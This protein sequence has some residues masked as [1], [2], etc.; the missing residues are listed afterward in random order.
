VP[1]TARWMLPENRKQALSPYASEAESKTLQMLE[2]AL[3][4]E[5]KELNPA[6]VEK[7]KATAPKDVEDLL[8]YLEER[9]NEYARKA[10]EKLA[11]RA[12]AESKAMRE[13][14]ES[15]QQHIKNSIAKYDKDVVQLKIQ[16]LENEFKQMETNRKYWDKRLEYLEQELLTE[17]DRVRQ[18]YEVKARRIEPVGL[19]YLCPAFEE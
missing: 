5:G 17:P 2:E 19:V 3:I 1:I 14:L 13:I 7:Y 18:V 4:I 9:G 6:D 8:Q 11:K 15:Q 10:E 12:E 16:F